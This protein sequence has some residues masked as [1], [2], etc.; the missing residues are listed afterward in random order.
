MGQSFILVFRIVILGVFVGLISATHGQTCDALPAGLVGWWRGEGNAF[1]TVSGTA[2]TAGSGTGFTAGEVGDAFSLDGA[3]GYIRIPSS[4][5]LNLGLQGGLTLEAWINPSDL[6]GGHP[7]LEWNDDNAGLPGLIFWLGHINATA[8]YL[9]ADLFDGHSD[10]IIESD[11]GT[12]AVNSPQHVALTY[13]KTNGIARLFVNGTLVK[14]QTLGTVTVRNTG[15][16]YIGARLGAG[17]PRFFQGIIDEPSVYGRALTT[18]EIAAIFAAGNA[19]KCP[20]PPPTFITQ[21][22]SQSVALGNPVT[23][24]VIASNALSY[25]WCFNGNTL[26]DQTNNT[27]LLPSA[28]FSDIGSYSV[29][30]SNLNGSVTSTNAELVVVAS[31]CA[32]APAGLIAWWRGESTSVDIVGANTTELA[33]GVD[34]G[35]GKVGLGFRFDGVDDYVHVSRSS[36]LDIGTGAG[37]TLEAWINPAEV[38]GAHPILEWNDNEASSPGLIFWLG[39]I[40]TTTGFLHAD[41]FDGTSNHVIE[42]APGTIAANTLQHVALTYE[43]AGGVARLFIN[44]KMVIQQVL[45]SVFPRTTSDLNIGARLGSVQP[46]FFAGIIDEPSIYNRALGTNEIAAI[47]A[48]GS[49]GKCPIIRITSITPNNGLPHLVIHGLTGRTNF[50]ERST[51][52]L[53]WI[54]IGEAADVGDDYFEYDETQASTARARFY[55]IA[56][57]K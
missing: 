45:G 33:N 51:D 9:H 42:S 44:G 10:H 20:P 49:E 1:D 8:G 55:R 26:S 41:L 57:P 21:P 36:Q 38:I 11:A 46:R 32:T 25:Q 13:D 2:G 14:Q 40:N 48:A 22:G 31:S 43:R 29:I 18:N 4:T 12:I 52:L 27:F 3:N 30:V 19:G 35:L 7:I 24:S 28:Q 6:A 34:Y 37:F 54:Q 5:N 56:S 39:H 50:V 17:Q 16:L 53:H 15:N 23:F 47:Y